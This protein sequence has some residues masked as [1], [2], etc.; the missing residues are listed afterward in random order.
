MSQTSPWYNFRLVWREMPCRRKVQFA[1]LLALTIFSTVAEVVSIGAILPFIA[2]LLD[3]QR[4][5][6]IP[7]VGAILTEAG[8]QDPV[9]LRVFFTL[10]FITLAVLSAAVRMLYFWS[11]LRLCYAICS[12]FA[13]R[14]FTRGLYRDYID[15]ARS[16]SSSLLVGLNIKIQAV[17]LGL[18][19]PVTTLLGAVLLI[20]GI[21]FALILVDPRVALV[22]LACGLMI[23]SVVLL[24]TRSP[25]MRASQALSENLTEM[26]RIMQVATGGLREILTDNS[27]EHFRTMFTEV[28]RRLRRNQVKISFLGGAPRYV[29]EALFLVLMALIAFFVGAGEEDLAAALPVLAAFALGAQK[30]LPAVQQV[31][32]SYASIVG[33][34]VNVRDAI[35]LF[36]GQ[37]AQTL[38]ATGQPLPFTS[39]LELSDVGVRYNAEGQWALRSVDLSIRKGERIGVIGPTGSGKSSLVDLIMGLLAPDEGSI[40]VDGKIIADDERADWRRQIAHVPQSVF[41]T[42]ATVSGNITFGLPHHT[43]D[44]DR[45]REAAKDAQI[46]TLLDKNAGE[47]GIQLS[48]GQ[49]QRVGIA[50]ALY[51]AADIIVLDEATSALDSATE[52]R[53]METI[54]A[55]DGDL[56][57]IMVAHRLSTLRDCDRIIVMEAGRIMRICSY[58]DLDI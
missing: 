57:L 11:T 18:L 51:R 25:L 16:H 27:Q 2:V 22:L 26:M 21:L 43:L 35:A 33:Q 32:Q 41:L 8:L 36:S 15:H 20:T 39:T 37:E 38:R 34:T 56:T 24:M 17:A 9:R 50:R 53:V 54:Y 29:T 1:A 30:M 10:V 13:D 42:D 49:R 46:E 14:A 12:D 7:W 23:Y 44:M 19:V 6:A 40:S 58:E 31:Y 47:R 28:E 55:L 4:V 3:P 52:T 45:V 48:G 5:L